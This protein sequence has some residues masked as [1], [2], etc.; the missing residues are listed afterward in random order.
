[1]ENDDDIMKSKS[2]YSYASVM[3]D[4]IGEAFEILSLTH[5]EKI[6][7]SIKNFV[8]LQTKI[9]VRLYF[10]SKLSG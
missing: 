7:Q 9:Y 3:K 2:K 1:M 6:K 4:S 10:V 5:L 8:F